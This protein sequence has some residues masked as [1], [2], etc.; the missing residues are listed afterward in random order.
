MSRVIETEG[1]DLRTNSDGTG[2]AARLDPEAGRMLKGLVDQQKARIA[3][4]E[5]ENKELLQ[6]KMRCAQID[7]HTVL[8]KYAVILDPQTAVGLKPKV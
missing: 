8:D 4:L 6:F 5:K 7:I 3:E 2:N 1:A